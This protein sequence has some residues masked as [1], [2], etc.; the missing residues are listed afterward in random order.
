[1]HFVIMTKNRCY[2]LLLNPMNPCIIVLPHIIPFSFDGE[3]DSGDNVQAT[4]HV[5][6]GD[7]PLDIR[8]LFNQKRMPSYLGVVVSKMGDRSSF[9]SISSV[10][11]ENNGSYT[12]LASNS[13]GSYNF[14]TDLF[15]NGEFR[16]I[17][18]MLNQ[19]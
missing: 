17:L 1:M 18:I 8:W 19:C 2:E 11:A 9:L 15:V 5:K 7:L 4:C 3:A 10:K 12:C 6:K 14:S 16:L 13:A